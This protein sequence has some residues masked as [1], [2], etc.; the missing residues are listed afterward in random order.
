MTRKYKSLNLSLISLRKAPNIYKNK[1]LN[2]VKDVILW[3]LLT[4]HALTCVA[5]LF[6]IALVLAGA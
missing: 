3:F 4:L 5:L 2:K 1:N 6:S